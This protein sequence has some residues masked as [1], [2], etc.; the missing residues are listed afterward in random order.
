MEINI[1]EVLRGDVDWL[2]RDKKT[3][4]NEKSVREKSTYCDKIKKYRK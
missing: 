2:Q 3:N 1:I 4:C